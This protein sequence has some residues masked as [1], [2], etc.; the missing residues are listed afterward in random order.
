MTKTVSTARPVTPLISKVTVAARSQQ[1]MLENANQ[2]DL[3]I[4][5]DFLNRTNMTLNYIFSVIMIF[6][7]IVAYHT[8]IFIYFKYYIS[9]SIT[10]KNITKN[11]LEN[12]FEL[13]Y[14]ALK[15]EDNFYRK[16]FNQ[17]LNLGDNMN[18]LL[19]QTANGFLSLTNQIL[20]NGFLFQSN[21]TD[22]ISGNLCVIYT[23][24]NSCSLYPYIH[25]SGLKSLVS[26]FLGKVNDAKTFFEENYGSIK[27]LPTL[28]TSNRFVVIRFYI[29]NL[30]LIYDDVFNQ[31]NSNFQNNLDNG[32][33]ILIIVGILFNVYFCFL[34]IVRLRQFIENL[35]NEENLCNRLVTEIPMEIINVNKH[36]RDNLSVC[37]KR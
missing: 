11:I 17:Q 22:V 31:F 34:M 2:P 29:E 33:I 35:V 27:D 3:I 26:F 10:T 4:K 5:K 12:K 18:Q 16:T 23:N 28:Y 8:F 14:L 36:F 20:N 30:K 7:L 6:T 37:F 21:I 19:N 1:T 13:N 9:V 25:E 15:M 32:Y 24:L